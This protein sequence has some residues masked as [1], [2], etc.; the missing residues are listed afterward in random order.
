MVSGL[1]AIHLPLHLASGL[2][3]DMVALAGIWCGLEGGDTQLHV[4]T[5]GARLLP[6]FSSSSLGV[7]EFSPFSWVM[8]RQ[9]VGGAGNAWAGGCPPSPR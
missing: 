3:Q 8:L 2:A 1:E 4:V 5:R 9:L 6:C 7:L